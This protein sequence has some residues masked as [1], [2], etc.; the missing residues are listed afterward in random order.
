MTTTET[1]SEEEAA[2]GPGLRRPLLWL[3]LALLVAVDLLTKSWAWGYVE[4]ENQ[5]VFPVESWHWLAITKVYNSGGVFGMLQGY[6]LPLTLF[7]AAAAG[8]IVWLI[9]RQPAQNRRGTFTL[10]LLGAGALGNLYDNLSRWMPWPG[11]GRV[12]DFI[13][14]DLGFWPFHPWPVFN[15]ADSCITVGFVLLLTGIAKISVQRTEAAPT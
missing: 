6:T 2:S 10:G 3:S 15:F 14:I 8:V 1:A 4:H 12:R 7:R 9:A 13:H 11:D 5:L